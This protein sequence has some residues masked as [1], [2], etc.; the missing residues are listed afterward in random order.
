MIATR[1]VAHP[2]TGPNRW[3]VEAKFTPAQWA[4]FL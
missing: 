4:T 2:R 1:L 3:F